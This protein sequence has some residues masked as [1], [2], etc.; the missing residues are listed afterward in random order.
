MSRTCTGPIHPR[1][2]SPDSTLLPHV[3]ELAPADCWEGGSFAFACQDTFVRAVGANC[4]TSLTPKVMQSDEEESEAEPGLRVGW[5][6][7]RRG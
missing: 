7:D 1:H 6:D 5:S 4:Q 2:I 3:G